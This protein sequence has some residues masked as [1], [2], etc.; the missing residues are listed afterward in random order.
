MNNVLKKKDYRYFD[1]ARQEAEKSDY[2]NISVGCVL[3]YKNHIIGSGHNSNKTCPQ[4]KRANKKRNFNKATN[5]PIQHS[6]HAEIAAIRSV[7]YTV[8]KSICWRDVK[9]YIYRICP[10]LDLGIGMAR[11]CPG[12]MSELKKKGVQHF[13]YTTSD[14]F[15]YEKVL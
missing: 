8:D 9:V 12:C 10:G 4:Q 1:F 2:K 11:S 15:A 14:G 3:V 6:L 5:K 7:P 13:Y